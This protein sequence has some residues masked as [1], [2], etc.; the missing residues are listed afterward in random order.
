MTTPR[1]RV[2]VWSTGG[3]GSNAIRAIARR[4][5]LDLVGVWV[6][7]PEKV[8]RDA[9]EL[10]GIDLLG[11]VATDDAEAVLALAPDVAWPYLQRA[12]DAV[13]AARA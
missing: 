6:H 2:A 7:T 1:R 11:I 9:G 12:A 13:A 8:G 3:V 10:A 4:P 5:D